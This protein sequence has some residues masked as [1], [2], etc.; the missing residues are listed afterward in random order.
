[1]VAHEFQGKGIGRK[2]LQLAIEEMKCREGIEIIEICYGPE[3]TAAKS[4]YFS[5]GFNEAGLYDDGTEAYA[6]IHVAGSKLSVQA[7]AP[8]PLT[9]TSK[10][11][12]KLVE[13]TRDNFDAVV[14]LELEEYQK[15]FI[16]PNVDSIAGSMFSPFSHLNRL[17]AI[18]MDEKVV[19]FVRYQ[20]GEI[21]EFD[22][23]ECTI[24]QFMID[25]QHQNTGIGKAAM[26][27]LLEEIKS[28]SDRCNLVD[29]Y[30]EPHNLVAKKLYS[31]LGFKEVGDRGDGT[32]IAERSI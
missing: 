3:N 29:I 2:A 17:R 31:S 8:E 32:V 14:E 4:L 15:E 13:I 19:G 18:C 6:Q 7:S 20:Y 26:S 10:P 1:M 23:K 12:I 21:G 24:W 27:L 5:S 16:C 22:E 28:N 30:Y 25:R 11:K 9:D